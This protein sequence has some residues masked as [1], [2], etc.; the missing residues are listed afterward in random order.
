MNLPAK[1]L[2][3]PVFFAPRITHYAPR[4]THFPACTLLPAPCTLFGHPLH[5]ACQKEK[6]YYNLLRFFFKKKT[7]NIA[8]KTVF[9]FFVADKLYYCPQLFANSNFLL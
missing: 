9:S 5:N 6:T 3:M 7:A 2:H 8:L 1:I 4:T